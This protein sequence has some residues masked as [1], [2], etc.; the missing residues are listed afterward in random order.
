MEKYIKKGYGF[1]VWTLKSSFLYAERLFT[2]NI[3][4]QTRWIKNHYV[5]EARNAVTSVQNDFAQGLIL[6]GAIIIGA[7][8]AFL[9]LCIWAPLRSLVS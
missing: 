7:I 8:I 9:L 6:A 3:P 4:L 2:R 1:A 5:P